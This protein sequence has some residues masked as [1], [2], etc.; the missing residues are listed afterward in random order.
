MEMENKAGKLWNLNFILLWQGQLVSILGEVVYGLVLGFWVLETTGS[1]ALMGGLMAAS[2]LPRIIVSP[3]AGVV[4]DRTDRRRLLIAMD[5]IR[6]LAVGF[7]GISAIYGFIQIW[8]VFVAGV[9][10]GVCGAFFNPAATSVIPDI[11]GKSRIMQANSIFSMVQTGGNIGGQSLSG[12]LFQAVGASL[13]F[14]FSGITYLFSALNLLFMKIPRYHHKRAKSHFRA[15]LKEGLSFTWRF[16]GL[17]N[18]ILVAAILNF[19][20]TMVIMLFLPYYVKT[21]GLGPVKYGV[22]MGFF[23]GGALLGMAITAIVKFPPAKRFMYFILFGAVS[24]GLLIAFPSIRFFPAAI[25]ML[26]I[27]GLCL[28]ILNVFV[29]STMQIIVP[30]DKRGKVLALFWMVTQGLTPIAQGVGGVL[31]EF[32]PISS[33][34][35][36]S[37]AGALIGCLPL[38]FIPSFRRFICYDPDKQTLESVL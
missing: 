18:L 12:V 17:R 14:L 21:P 24:M 38:L 33:L 34:I 16:R 26:V 11:A 31:A 15:D 28:A 35:S 32:V 30:Q 6:G 10:L 36:F 4:V 8:I 22:G 3:F 29:S 7:V 2:T 5:V 20:G 25:A 23:T 19:F 13:I 9:V 27:A 1:T 37:L